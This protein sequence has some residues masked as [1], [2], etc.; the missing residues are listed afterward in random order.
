MLSIY[1][2][3][4]CG[5]LS[6]VYAIWATQSVMAADAGNQR[7]QEI[8]PE[9]I[10]TMMTAA[11][12]AAADQEWTAAQEIL[13]QVLRRAPEFR[14]AQFLLGAVHKENGNLGQAEM[15]LSAVVAATPENARARRLLAETRLALDK[16]QEAR[17][18]LE[19]L[20][21][22]ADPDI[23]SLSMAAASVILAVP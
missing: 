14:M 2:I 12:I 4:A 1:F 3:I 13:Q 8:A 17:Q 5:V 20:I 10:R 9:D 23:V 6:I 21:S 15:Y 7:M 22:G 19:P 16:D 11:R 18:A